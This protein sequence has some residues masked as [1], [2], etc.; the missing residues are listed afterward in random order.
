[1]HKSWDSYFRA[2][3]SGA[4]PGHAFVPPPGLQPGFSAPA[5]P[6]AASPAAVEKAVREKLSLS[7]LIRAYQV[8]GHEVSNLDPLGLRNT[9][10]HSVDELH[11]KQYGFTEGDLDRAFDMKV[12]VHERAGPAPPCP[13]SP[14]HTFTRTHT[15]APPL[16]PPPRR[17]SRA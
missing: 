1:M 9:P 10:L 14:S 12:R 2:V 6:A 3:E 17:A 5:A 7:H 15:H 8:R 16:P 4:A 13:P 11:Y